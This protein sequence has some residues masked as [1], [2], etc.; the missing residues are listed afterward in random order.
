MLTV[1]HSA[2]GNAQP[3]VTERVRFEACIKVDMDALEI[4]G[5]SVHKDRLDRLK[6][7]PGLLLAELPVQIG[8]YRCYQARS[9]SGMAIHQAALRLEL[10]CAEHP[11]PHQHWAKVANRNYYLLKIIRQKSGGA[12]VI[13]KP[14]AT[15]PAVEVTGNMLQFRLAQAQV[16]HMLIQFEVPCAIEKVNF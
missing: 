1:F 2:T 5:E 7:T 15:P 3:H 11:I 8:G 9:D 10:Y 14:C 13:P 12:V 16:M 6:C 4:V